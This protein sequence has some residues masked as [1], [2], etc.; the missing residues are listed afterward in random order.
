MTMPREI[1]QAGYKLIKEFEAGPQ[2]DSRPALVPYLCP[3]GKLTNGWGNTHNV[4]PGVAITLAQAE[5][6]LERNLDWAEACVDEVAP[7]AN[8]NE[9]AAMVSLCFNIGADPKRGFPNS[10]VRRLFNRGD[11]A[12]AAASF[13]L[14]RKMTDPN[15][16][17]LV[18][19]GGLLRRRNVEAALFLT[20][21]SSRTTVAVGEAVAPTA[22]TQVAPPTLMPQAVAPEKS[23]TS[24]KTV[25]A[26]GVA[27][28]TGAASVADQTN[29]LSTTVTSVTQAVSSMQGLLKLGALGLSIVALAAVGY[30]LWRYVQ[31]R[32]RGEV[33][34]T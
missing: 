26:G 27:V 1:N 10:S 6:D 18:D 33:M 21:A 29:Q 11:K 7:G 12:G 9:F 30:M 20:P 31:K 23:A 2:G 15:T 3:A 22:V 16:G 34:S 24:S 17:Q 25:I 32:R 19:S 5:V 28:A 13:T 8:D 4:K 14:W